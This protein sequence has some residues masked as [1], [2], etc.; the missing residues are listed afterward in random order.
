MSGNKESEYTIAYIAGS[1]RNGSTLLDILLNNQGGVA[2]VGEVHRLGLYV[3]N[4]MMCSCG[5]SFDEC[6][7]WRNVMVK[8]T[9]NFVNECDAQGDIA[10]SDSQYNALTKY[11]ERLLLVA[12]PPSVFNLIAKRIFKDNFK[13]AEKSYQLF[14]AISCSYNSKLIVDSTKDARRLKY[15]YNLSPKRLK[16]VFLVRDGRPVALSHMTRKAISFEDALE[17]WRKKVRSI[18]LVLKNIPSSNVLF[19]KYE[20]L[21][22]NPK[23]TIEEINGFLGTAESIADEFLSLNKDLYHGLGGNPMRFRKGEKKIQCSDA[24]QQEITEEQL[25]FFDKKAGRLNKKFGYTRL[26]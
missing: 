7:F 26:F 25:I 15:L 8:D 22:S 2:S 5:A 1:G 6:S 16:V 23:C 11:F 14:D 13:K 17:E 12:L 19:V 4:N 20:D 18:L 21:C 3:K 10:M 9:I 24:W